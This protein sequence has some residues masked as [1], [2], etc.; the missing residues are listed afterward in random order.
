MP[1]PYDLSLRITFEGL[2]LLEL[3]ESAKIPIRSGC[4]AGA[5]GRCVIA[6]AGDLTA[7]SAIG[8][9]ERKCLNVLGQESSGKSRLAC[10]A[11]VCGEGTLSILLKER[12]S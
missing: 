8:E 3:A 11:R 12:N 10:Q 4:R 1:Q 2:S 5:C 6:I 7:V 9:R